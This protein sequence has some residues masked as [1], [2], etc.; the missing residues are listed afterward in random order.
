MNES[1]SRTVALVKGLGVASFGLGLSEILAPSK[2][3]DLAGVDETPRARKIIQA[4]GVR[5]C[6]HGAALLLGSEKLVWTR[7]AGDVLDVAVL[8]AGVARRGPGRRTRGSIA[9]AALTVIGGLDLYAALSTTGGQSPRH[10][11][12]Q[13]HESLRA[14]VT[15]LRSPDE[16]YNYWR[17]LENLPSFMHHLQSVTIDADGRSHWVANAPVGQPIRWDARIVDDVPGKRISWQSLPGSGIDNS[18]CVDFTPDGS[19][20]GTEIRVTIGYQLPGGGL[21][22]AAAALLGESPQQQVND[23]LRRFKQIIETGQVTRSDGS[24]GG[25]VSFQQMH[26][27]NAQPANQG[28]QA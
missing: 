18:G 22:K 6:G 2:V 15:V 4:L 25:T 20:R 27:Q 12:G 23:D 21:A 9:L 1:A 10:A 3:A 28:S 11:G 24:P 14:A 5:E 19:G 8:A 17:D 7:V 26:Q 13:H 16:V